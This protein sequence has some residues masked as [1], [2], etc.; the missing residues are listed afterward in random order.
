MLELGK[1]LVEFKLEGGQLAQG[2]YVLDLSSRFDAVDICMSACHMEFYSKFSM[3]VKF[4][5]GFLTSP[6]HAK[7]LLCRCKVS[8][9][10]S[11]FMKSGS[12]R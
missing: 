3:D 11:S 5:V 8:Y 4:F 2:V 9:D 1:I 10:L 6:T 7:G 12:R